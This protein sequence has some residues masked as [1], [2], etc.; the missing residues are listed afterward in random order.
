MHTHTHTSPC[1]YKDRYKH[2]YT[3]CTKE[4]RVLLKSGLIFWRRKNAKQKPNAERTLAHSLTQTHTCMEHRK[5]SVSEYRMFTIFCV[6]ECV[7]VC[8]IPCLECLFVYLLMFASQISNCSMMLSYFLS[9]SSLCFSYHFTHI[10]LAFTTIIYS[11][12]DNSISSSFFLFFARTKHVCIANIRTYECVSF[13]HTQC[14]C[15]WV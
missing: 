6:L 5:V 15:I 3:H 12:I 10:L 11:S 9:F 8:G 7:F 14:M 13:V 1:V 2:A 4:R